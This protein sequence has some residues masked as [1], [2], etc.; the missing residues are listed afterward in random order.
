MIAGLHSNSSRAGAS[1]LLPP[2]FPDHAAPSGRGSVP[3]NDFQDWGEAGEAGEAGEEGEAGEAGEAGEEGEPVDAW[4]VVKKIAATTRRR[5]QRDVGA[6][7][8]ISWMLQAARCQTR[9]EE[10]A[11]AVEPEAGLAPTQ[12]R[13]AR[14]RG[15]CAQSKERSRK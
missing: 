7:P 14:E 4:E 12:A 2:L 8:M 13:L 1:P 11:R 5:V 3:K 10:P 9:S 6:R 15:A